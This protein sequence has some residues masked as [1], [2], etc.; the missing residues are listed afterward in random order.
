M[1]RDLKIRGYVV[2]Q[3]PN[4]PLWVAIAAATAR[5]VLE[6]GALEDG[7]EAT[8]YLALTIWAYE[9]AANGVNRLRR[10]LGIVALA[11]I[12]LSLGRRFGA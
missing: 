1:R 4:A 11:L 8:F 6:D 12:A 5:A 9:E 2:A 10:A 3:A 7:A